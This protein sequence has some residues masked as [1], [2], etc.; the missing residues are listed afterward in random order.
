MSLT[1]NF[2][3][4]KANK[5]GELEIPPKEFGTKKLQVEKDCLEIPIVGMKKEKSLEER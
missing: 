1:V 3:N 4:V 5:K 2:A